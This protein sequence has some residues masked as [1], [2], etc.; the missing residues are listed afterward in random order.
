[1]EFLRGHFKQLALRPGKE[2]DQSYEA[3]LSLIEA[4]SLNLIDLG[5]FKVA[6]LQTIADRLAYFLCPY[7]AKTGLLTPQGEPIDLL[8]WLQSAATQPVERTVLLGS[9]HHLPCRLLAF[10]LTQEAADRRR[11]K[12]KQKAKREGKAI[13]KPHLALLG[14][15]ILVSNVPDTM[16][17]LAQVPRVY[18]IRWQ[19]ELTFKLWKSY[20]GLR[21]LAGWRQERLLT[22]LYARLIGLVLTQFLLAPLRLPFGPAANREVSP[23]QVRKILQR[24]A[25]LL[26]QALLTPDRLLPLLQEMFSHISR[27]GFKDKRRKKPNLYYA[28]HLAAYVFSL[29]LPVEA[30][31]DLLPF[32][33]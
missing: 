24:F 15:F 11:Y 20:G 1:L 10:P 17:T 8:N 23:V 21:H 7:L 9:Q 12:A 31:L 6:S 14:W 26:N 4:G 13:T 18:R 2:V 22:E 3:Y 29:P 28:L 33:A 5:Y 19:I 27:F 30:D 16:L 25:R 32:L